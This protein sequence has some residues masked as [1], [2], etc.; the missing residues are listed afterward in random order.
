MPPL[1]RKR[2]AS[3]N[4]DNSALAVAKRV[5]PPTNPAGHPAEDED[6]RQLVAGQRDSVATSQ[7][8]QRDN[9][10][11]ASPKHGL[12]GPD[13]VLGLERKWNPWRD[14]IPSNLADAMDMA[15]LYSLH[16]QELVEEKLAKKI[17]IL[18][19]SGGVL[20]LPCWTNRQFAHQSLT[21]SHGYTGAK[22]STHDASSPTYWVVVPCQTIQIAHPCCSS[23]SLRNGVFNSWYVQFDPEPRARKIYSPSGDSF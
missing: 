16:F 22:T 3:L 23:T 19:V 20:Y 12:G 10:P 17:T 5:A 6:N 9:L 18:N 21:T 2:K 14:E 8:T 15:D 13:A 4:D 7:V 1:L 11:F